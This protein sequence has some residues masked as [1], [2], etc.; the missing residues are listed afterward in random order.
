MKILRILKGMMVGA[1][2][3][4]YAGSLDR[5]A[6]QAFIGSFADGVRGAQLG[7]SLSD[8]V[9]ELSRKYP[10]HV[11]EEEGNEPLEPSLRWEV[12]E[13]VGKPGEHNWQQYKGDLGLVSLIGTHEEV[14]DALGKVYFSPRN[15]CSTWMLIEEGK[16][17]QA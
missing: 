11:F 6:Y 14:K 12:W 1:L 4:A 7:K 13:N 10:G 3:G 9:S 5:Q 16:S 8:I 17:A 15:Y 2:A